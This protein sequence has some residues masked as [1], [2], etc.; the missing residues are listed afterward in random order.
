[1]KTDA[2]HDVKEF[3]TCVFWFDRIP[4]ETVIFA[5]AFLF[6]KWLLNSIFGSVLCEKSNVKVAKKSLRCDKKIS[7]WFQCLTIINQTIAILWF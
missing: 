4:W 3:E 1:L 5:I 6:V 2:S 7:N